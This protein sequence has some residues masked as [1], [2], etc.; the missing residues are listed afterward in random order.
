[1]GCISNHDGECVACSA[2]GLP[3]MLAQA[4]SWGCHALKHSMLCSGHGLTTRVFKMASTGQQS[5]CDSALCLRVLLRLPP[6]WH[7]QI[8]DPRCRWIAA[9][10]F[11]GGILFMI[12]SFSGSS[13]YVSPI[14]DIS[15]SLWGSAIMRV[16]EHFR[17]LGREAYWNTAT[18]GRSKHRA[19]ERHDYARRILTETCASCTACA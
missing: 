18:W 4:S 6:L 14:F 7:E 11:Y 5:Y 19:A 3:Q 13:Q 15:R 10:A 8:C 2:L 17:A 16:A 12:G 1:M 9:C